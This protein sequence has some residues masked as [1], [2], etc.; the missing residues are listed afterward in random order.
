VL[1]TVSRVDGGMI[2]APAYSDVPNTRR[3][4]VI[5]DFAPSSGTRVVPIFSAENSASNMLGKVILS[6]TSTVS[7]LLDF[8]DS[9][10]MP[11]GEISKA[12]LAEVMH[13]SDPL[14]RL[15]PWVESNSL[16]LNPS[17]KTDVVPWQV[18][19]MRDTVALTPR[20]D[21]ETSNSMIEVPPGI[22][23]NQYASWRG[24]PLLEMPRDQGPAIAA[25]AIALAAPPPQNNAPHRSDE[26]AI[27]RDAM[28]TPT[29]TE[30]VSRMLKGSDDGHSLNGRDE[31]IHKFRGV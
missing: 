3:S 7:G 24:Q 12:L 10:T 1:L 18:P 9:A 20:V 8:E 2:H 17:G 28:L 23:P 6:P 31:N 14:G 16:L 19:N 25:V 26:D 11:Q 27:P 29:V 5:E 21:L 4:P 13:A 15:S 30:V 22:V